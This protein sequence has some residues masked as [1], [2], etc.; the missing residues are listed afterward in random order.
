MLTAIATANSNNKY[1]YQLYRVKWLFCLVIYISIILFSFIIFI[2][3]FFFAGVFVLA[4]PWTM[5]RAET[6]FVLSCCFLG[7]ALD[8]L[9]LRQPLYSPPPPPFSQT[10]RIPSEAAFF[11]SCPG[12]WTFELN[13]WK[14]QMLLYT[15]PFIVENYFVLQLTSLSNC[16]SVFP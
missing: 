5:T 12:T 8:V 10:D 11:I 4:S 13:S 7:L 15:L 1:S 2:F 14:G 3:I 9:S 6:C 16:L